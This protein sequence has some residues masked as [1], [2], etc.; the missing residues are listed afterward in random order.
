MHSPLGHVGPASQRFPLMDR[1]QRYDLE[2]AAVGF[3]QRYKLDL[4]AIL[5]AATC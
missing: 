1:V 4:G 3:M 2:H 5:V